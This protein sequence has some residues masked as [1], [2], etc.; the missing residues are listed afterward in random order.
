MRILVAGWRG[1]TWAEHGD[2]LAQVLDAWVGVHRHNLGGSVTLVHGMCHLGGIDLMA[3]S[4]AQRRGWTPERH[5]AMHHP[6]QDF[7][8][9]PTAGPR[10][11]KYM[12][13]LGADIA[14][15]F[16]H[17]TSHRGTHGMAGE[18]IRANIPHI[19]HPI[20]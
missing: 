12:A 18:L 2:I 13:S 8:E 10:R 14:F 5:P 4:H 9:W 19:T 6:A 16:P 7:G 11:N 15:L 3:D 17:R 1:A 20:E